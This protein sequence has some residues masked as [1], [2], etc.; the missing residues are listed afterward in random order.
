MF[1]I[2]HASVN[3]DGFYRKSKAVIAGFMIRGLNHLLLI[4][5]TSMAFKHADMAN[6][7]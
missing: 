6:I 5:V 4:L 2:Y 7:N 1:L 3:S